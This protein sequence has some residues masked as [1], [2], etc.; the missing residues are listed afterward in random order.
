MHS[1]CL[2]Q[3]REGQPSLAAQ[4]FPRPCSGPLSLL[5]KAPLLPSLPPASQHA[6][7]L[8]KTLLLLLLVVVVAVVVVVVVVFPACA[9]VISFFGSRVVNF[10][11]AI[12]MFI[13]ARE[14]SSYIILC[15][16][17]LYDIVI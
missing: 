14:R 7:L 13:R 1:T 11:L 10:A 6:L 2:Q 17:V 12:A 8:F 4:D 3:V 9:E 5:S 16:V 15:Y